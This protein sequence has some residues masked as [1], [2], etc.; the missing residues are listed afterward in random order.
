MNPINSD[1][2][3]KITDVHKKMGMY[4]R[5]YDPQTM[6]LVMQIGPHREL[7]QSFPG[8]SAH[9]VI[10]DL[11][12]IMQDL[13]ACGYSGRLPRPGKIPIP[14]AQLMA[15]F[16]DLVLRFQRLRDA[17]PVG[18]EE[19]VACVMHEDQGRVAPNDERDGWIYSEC[20]KGTAYKSIIDQLKNRKG[21]DKIGT[22]QGI[23]ACANRY[24]KREDLPLP[25]L[26]REK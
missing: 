7:L 22:V 6:P 15:K 11:F 19:K 18:D 5:R 3:S 26:R 25:P 12:Y 4:G 24:A 14:S 13:L 21:W 9:S 8:D 23:R 16:R 20:C 1:P 10:F 17:L 2:H